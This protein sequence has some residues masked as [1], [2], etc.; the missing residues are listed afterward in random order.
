M[1]NKNN[2]SISYATETF[3][4]IND[5]NIK[6]SKLGL[7]DYAKM[8]G[9][10]R[11]LIASVISV[12]QG[13]AQLMEDVTAAPEQRAI[14]LAELVSALVER[15]VIQVINF[16]DLCVPELG[17]DYIEQKVGPYDLVILFDAILEVNHINKA[18]DEGKKLIMNYMRSRGEEI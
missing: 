18:I 6:V 1:D 15:N 9:I 10:L 2:E 11:E 4:Q 7:L 3:R 16:I 5:R 13:Q 8:S 12:I 14:M 17:R